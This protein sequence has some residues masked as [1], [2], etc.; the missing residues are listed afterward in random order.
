MSLD[1]RSLIAL[2]VFVIILI[3]LITSVAMNSLLKSILIGVLAL[4]LLLAIL[5]ILGVWTY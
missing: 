5:N 4:G 2:A 1:P 3:Y